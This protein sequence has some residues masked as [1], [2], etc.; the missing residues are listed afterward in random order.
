MKKIILASVATMFVVSM[1]P[2]AFAKHY[3]EQCAITHGNWNNVPADS[4]YTASGAGHDH[5]S[6]NPTPAPNTPE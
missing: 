1:T 4:C 2:V 5:E 3:K 6:N